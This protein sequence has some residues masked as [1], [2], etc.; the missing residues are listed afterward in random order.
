MRKMRAPC[1]EIPADLSLLPVSVGRIYC[2]NEVSQ[3]SKSGL[4][5]PTT[6]LLRT[7]HPRECPRPLVRPGKH[8]SSIARLR[9]AV[10]I[11]LPL[12]VRSCLAHPA[13]LQSLK[14]PAPPS[15]H[16]LPAYN[17]TDQADT[18]RSIT[19]PTSHYLEFPSRLLRLPIPQSFDLQ[20][21]HPTIS[22]HANG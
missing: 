5:R 12:T 18:T 9:T 7:V 13:I 8:A 17:V 2:S 6:R 16:L 4:M 20:I 10:L 15:D 21:P 11:C 19:P 1:L 22:L 3:P 14:L